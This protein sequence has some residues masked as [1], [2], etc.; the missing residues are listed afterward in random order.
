MNSSQP[1]DKSL[2]HVEQEQFNG[3]RVAFLD[4]LNQEVNRLVFGDLVQCRKLIAEIDDLRKQFVDEDRARLL[5][6]MARFYHM[7]GQPAD[8]LKL[9]Q[10]AERIYRRLGDREAPA[11][12]AKAKIDALMYLGKYRQALE[13]GRWAASFFRRRKRQVDLAQVLTN[14]GNVYHRMDDATRALRHYTKARDV[15]TTDVPPNFLATIDYNRANIL[16]NLNRLS[17]AEALYEDAG[18]KYREAEM[19]MAA[20]HCDYSIAYLQFLRGRFADA[21]QRFERVRDNLDRLGDRRGKAIAELD[22]VEIFLATNRFSEVQEM[23]GD[24]T[25]ELGSLKL[26]YELGKLLVYAARAAMALGDFSSAGH[27]L[28]KAKTIFGREGNKLWQAIVL[29]ARAQLAFLRGRKKQAE[30]SARQSARAFKA[31]RD[32]IRHAYA[33]VF[34]AARLY[35][36]KEYAKA[37]R[38]LTPIIRKRRALPASVLL[39]VYHLLG[40]IAN[41]LDQQQQGVEFLRTA[42]KHLRTL[43][44]GISPDESRM[45]FLS[46]K[47]SVFSDLTDMLIRGGRHTGA[48][49]IAQEARRQLVDESRADIPDLSA[50]AVPQQLSERRDALRAQLRKLYTPTPTRQRGVG[51]DV[52]AIRK[53]ED[54]LWHTEQRIKRHF[55]ERV[56]AAPSDAPSLKETQK[57][58]DGDTV[59]LTYVYLADDCGVF[60]IGKDTVEFVRLTK[61]VPVIDDL[62][63]RLY[64]FLEKNAY[65]GSYRYRNRET[66]QS[67]TVS[68]LNQLTNALWEPLEEHVRQFQNAVIIPDRKLSAVPFHALS[69]AKGPMVYERYRIEMAQSLSSWLT[70]HGN[71]GST[72]QPGVVFIPASGNSDAAV[73]ELAGIRKAFPDTG[74][75]RGEEA[76]SERFR[77]ALSE[78]AR[79]VHTI[80]HASISLANPFCSEILLDDGPFYA[81]DLFG[82]RIK[83]GLVTLSACQTGRPGFFGDLDTTALSDVFVAAGADVSLGSL[84]PVSDEETSRFMSQFYRYWAK[85]YDVFTAWRETVD[86]IRKEEANPY[87]WAAF[88]L[89]GY[90]S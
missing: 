82:E 62:I 70:R 14:M 66:I 51:G 28:T 12:I 39:P 15:I 68:Y 80:S 6:M 90:V 50:T 34:I 33:V 77:Q 67:G 37:R 19:E 89:A 21:L 22:I 16:A 45:I 71:A 53:T 36:R 74:V 63:A 41:A 76:T 65:P 7:T 42:M 38:S 27:N 46:D 24:L 84:W 43:T 54:K 8:A 26:D 4:W 85:N 1:S 25:D 52:Q 32:D 58:L 2:Q 30:E 78:P 59:L 87:Y 79:F 11:M 73:A 61:S 49:R 44:G 47:Y 83:S 13:V 48:F 9:Y 18:A 57:L 40:R 88:R 75:V 10:K 5:R 64:F 17:E 35:E 69:T 56:P 55:Y 31:L 20:E 81:F 3:D 86:Y 23:V 29:L 72:T 60:V